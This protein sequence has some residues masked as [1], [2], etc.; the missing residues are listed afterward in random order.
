[1]LDVALLFCV[2]KLSSKIYKMK[3]SPL[4]RAALANGSFQ[5]NLELKR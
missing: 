3:I 4:G 1:M 5:N 2:K